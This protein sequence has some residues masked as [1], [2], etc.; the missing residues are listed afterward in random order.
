MHS[1]TGFRNLIRFATS[2]SI[3]TLVVLTMAAQAQKYE[4]TRILP[5]GWT[6]S[7]AT[8]LNE[9]GHILLSQRVGFQ[10]WETYLWRG[11]GDMERIGGEIGKSIS[12]WDLNDNDEALVTIQ[13]KP[14]SFQNGNYSPA[15]AVP[16]Y[17]SREFGLIV[18]EREEWRSGP[19]EVA[20]IYPLFINNRREVIVCKQV[21]VNGSIHSGSDESF[22]FR[23]MFKGDSDSSKLANEV[24]LERLEERINALNESGSILI[25]AKGRKLDVRLDRNYSLDPMMEDNW[26]REDT[27]LTDRDEVIGFCSKRD[28]PSENPAKRHGFYIWS[29]T[30]G[31]KIKEFSDPRLIWHIH[32][33]AANNHGWM[34]L[35]D[36]SGRPLPQWKRWL[37][38]QIRSQKWVPD[39]MR[40]AVSFESERELFLWNGAELIDLKQFFSEDTGWNL[41]RI[42]TFV[43]EINNKGQIAGTAEYN[44]TKCAFLLTPVDE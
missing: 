35:Q 43:R 23:A 36:T 11:P 20:S 8:S 5:E 4:L 28:D 41:S 7:S 15:V 18:L 30:D 16:C 39:L 34:I 29:V 27:F 2:G 19:T 10:Y 1:T 17:W 44:G 13:E 42:G 22:L 25:S 40:S 33:K 14:E 31:L 32:A 12:A 38:R 21:W 26:L 37:R 6:N 24:E 9:S 3:L